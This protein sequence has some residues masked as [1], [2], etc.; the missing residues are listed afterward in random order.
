MAV[1]EQH[2]R[3]DLRGHQPTPTPV[4]IPFHTLLRRLVDLAGSPTQEG[5]GPVWLMQN[6]LGPSNGAV[7]GGQNHS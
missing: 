2:M 7:T 3:E 6:L 1:L 5:L 4:A